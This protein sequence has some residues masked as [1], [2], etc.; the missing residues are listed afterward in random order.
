MFSG[1][2]RERPRRNFQLAIE[3][4]ADRSLCGSVGLRDYDSRTRRAEF[5]LE[6]APSSWGRY[7]TAIEV[8]EAM[9]AFGF[10]SLG[11]EAV[12][13]HTAMDNGKIARL[14]AWFGAEP[15]S[16]ATD[17]TLVWVVSATAWRTARAARGL[18]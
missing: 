2:Q 7:R 15:A 8:G 9:L 6:L 12:F 4:K 11:L 17:R 10:E 3:N 13:G 18:S 5:G 16:S 1:W 14:A